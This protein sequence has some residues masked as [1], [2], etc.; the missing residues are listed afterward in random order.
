MGGGRDVERC[1]VASGLRIR[2]ESLVSF[3]GLGDRIISNPKGVERA[4]ALGHGQV[5]PCQAL[6]ANADSDRSHD[7]L[8]STASRNGPFYVRL[9]PND[10]HD[11]HVPRPGSADKFKSVSDDPH[12]RDFFAVL[13]E[14]DKQI[15][16]VISTIDELN[17]GKKTLILFHK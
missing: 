1:S 10:V 7:R 2:Y 9:F 4:R 13:E 5:I 3:E 12:V 6:G 16:R 11:A 14:M 17:L 15:G 8:H